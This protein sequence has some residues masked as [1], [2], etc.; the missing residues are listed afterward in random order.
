MSSTRLNMKL[1]KLVFPLKLLS[2][3]V[4][5]ENSVKWQPTGKNIRTNT[6]E[7][8]FQ[9][10][11]TLLTVYLPV[12]LSVHQCMCSSIVDVNTTSDRQ[13]MEQLEHEITQK[14]RERVSKKERWKRIRDRERLW[15]QKGG[16]IRETVISE[17]REAKL[18][19]RQKR[20]TKEK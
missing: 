15:G 20:Y 8:K 19:N 6:E 2:S 9:Q 5:V 16:W 18:Q 13:I 1:F 14:D 10:G 3:W 7:G 11:S 17:Y 4:S 12:H